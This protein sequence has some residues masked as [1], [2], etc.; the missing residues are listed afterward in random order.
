MPG[1]GRCRARGAVFAESQKR[2]ARGPEPDAGLWTLPS[3]RSRLRG[4]SEAERAR[5][6]ARCRAVDAA[7]LA[8]SSSRNLRSGAREARSR[9]RFL[10]LAALGVR[11]A[12][13]AGRPCPS[14]RDHRRA[15]AA[16]GS[17]ASPPHTS[18]TG[19]TPHHAP[20][21]AAREPHGQNPRITPRGPPHASPTGK[22]PHH[23]P[24]QAGLVKL[25]MPD[26]HNLTRL[27]RNAP[28]A[29]FC[30]CWRPALRLARPLDR[31]SA[32]P[33]P[34]STAS[35]RPEPQVPHPNRKSPTPTASPS[36]QPQARHPRHR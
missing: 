32:S 2:S 34:R 7:Q 26:M 12:G 35:P 6:G 30:M 5:P 20:R 13:S 28:N 25:C 21:P 17:Y 15:P 8:E 31:E 36:H 27:L 3:S 23:G 16:H 24:R 14:A 10:G 9:M 19:K 18:P 22:S 29:G 33:R 4:I 1:C 11:G